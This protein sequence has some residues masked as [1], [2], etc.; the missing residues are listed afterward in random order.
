[1]GLH[2]LFIAGMFVFIATMQYATKGYSQSK[3]LY[4]VV[5]FQLYLFKHATF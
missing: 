2:I 3:Q 5:L 4:F 1:M